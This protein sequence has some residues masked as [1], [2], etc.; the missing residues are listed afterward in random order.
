MRTESKCL[1]LGSGSIWKMQGL[2]ELGFGWPACNGDGRQSVQYL[3]STPY[4]V[5]N[6]KRNTEPQGYST[7][8]P[9]RTAA[10]MATGLFI[11]HFVAHGH[12]TLPHPPHLDSSCHMLSLSQHPSN[13]HAQCT[14]CGGLPHCTF[15]TCLVIWLTIQQRALPDSTSPTLYHTTPDGSS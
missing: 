4:I 5:L 8:Q 6:I 15:C 12:C 3:R 7:P 1:A 11:S 2:R 14:P 9:S 10:D 13:Y